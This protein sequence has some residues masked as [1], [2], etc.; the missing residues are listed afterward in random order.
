MKS[1]VKATYLEY[2][3]STPHC[4][5]YRT[6]DV[7]TTIPFEV[8][9]TTAADAPVAFIVTGVRR[10]PMKTEAGADDY[11]IPDEYRVFKNSLWHRSHFSDHYCGA[12]GLFPTTYIKNHMESR[13]YNGPTVTKDE[14]EQKVKAFAEDFLIIDGEVY[15][16]IGEPRYV[17]MTFGLGHNH[18]G[19]SLSVDNWYNGNIGKS[20]YFNALQRD[21][22]IASAK[23]TA[24]GRGDTDYVKYI[25]EWYDIKVLM[26]K[27]VKCN[28]Q[29]EHGD[30]D[31]FMNK[32]E[33]LA[34][35]SPDTTSAAFLVMAAT[36]KSL[37]G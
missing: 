23:K 29:V 28:P 31:P 3:L 36:L 32:L 18:G 37:K 22:A 8:E 26:P 33:S 17:I 25:G 21:E 14:L 34:S 1:E 2:Y 12:E 6:R 5:K 30:G 10:N 4:R 11:Y 27:M 9:E 24:L 20:R 35:A 16:P 13:L 7:K 19:T 15:E